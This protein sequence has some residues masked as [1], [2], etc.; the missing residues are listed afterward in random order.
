[1]DLGKAF[2]YQFETEDWWKVLLLTG[3]IALIPVVGFIYIYGWMMEIA[4]R[5]AKASNG[6]HVELPGVDFGGFLEKGFKGFVVGLIYSL[7]ALI[8]AIPLAIILPVAVSTMDDP[9][10]VILIASICCGGL[11]VLLSIAGGL[12]TYPAIV[13][14]QLKDT[15]K[16]GLDFK[17]M[18]AIFKAAIVPFLISIVAMA[19]VSPILSSLGALLCGFGVLLTVP[20]SI[21]LMGY[22]VG[23]AY[24][25]GVQSVASNDIV[26]F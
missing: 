11:A 7:P 8:V 20:Y 26:E 3:L 25:E 23:N 24:R 6:G 21:S 22:F 17:R 14:V 13:E 9:T 1:M 12:L 2:S 18:F 4:G 5:F 16:A 19:I 15:I 10:A